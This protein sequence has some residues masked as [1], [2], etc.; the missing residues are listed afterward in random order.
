MNVVFLSPAFP[1]HFF[2]FCTALR[3]RGVKVLGVGDTPAHE[4]RSELSAALGEYYHAPG[5]E[6]YE[7]AYRALAYLAWRHGRVD[8]VDSHSEH[9]L[10]L[11]AQ[12]REDFNIPGP[13]PAEL[14]Q[15]RSK[16]GMAEL[17]RQAGVPCP[18][19]ELTSSPER[20]RELAQRH[21]FPLVLKPDQGV[22]AAG[23]FQVSSEEQLEQ[24]LR[25][26]PQGYLAQPFV[27]GKIT[28]YDG[29]VDRQ[30]RIVFETSHLYSSGVMEALTQ[31]LDLYYFN[32]LEIPE[33]MSR[34][35]RRV[36]DVFGIRERFFHFELFELEEGGY[37]A[38]EVNLRPPG[39]YTTDM[40][41]YSADID[42]YRLWAALLSGDPLEDFSY[43]LKYHVAHVARRFGRRYEVPH[44]ALRRELGERLLVYRP[45]PPVFSGAMGDEMYLIRDPDLSRL[46]ET[47]RFIQA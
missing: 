29:L 5:M 39:G 21:G 47:I 3:E 16:S 33:E 19:G 31:G 8:R 44:E 43:E 18:E 35:G 11:E 2:L 10:S 6:Q 36:I 13:R 9:W 37:C 38:L 20:V 24:V 1:P 34:L 26:P 28:S 45:M 46:K 12:L 40:M 30:G 27:R 23:A 17:F 7:P 14:A 25:S 42:V 32:R 41:N 22:G 4:L 15:R